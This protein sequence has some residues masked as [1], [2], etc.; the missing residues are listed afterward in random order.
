MRLRS[1]VIFAGTILL[2][3]TVASLAEPASAP[4]PGAAATAAPTTT[5][6]TPASSTPSAGPLS[7]APAAPAAEAAPAASASAQADTNPIVCRTEAVT[8]SRL[9]A[10]RLCARQSEWDSMREDS[11]HSMAQWQ[12]HNPPPRGN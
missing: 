4:A 5:A 7:T 2:S 1:V 11:R 8:G 3:G 9:G 10:K 6:A 12:S